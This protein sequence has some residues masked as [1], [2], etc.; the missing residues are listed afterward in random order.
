MQYTSAPSRTRF[1]STAAAVSVAIASKQS[2][3]P[4]RGGDSWKWSETEN[5]SKPCA[6]PNF[7]RRRISS[8]GPPMWP[9][10]IPNV[11]AI[12]DSP[13]RSAHQE[14]ARHLAAHGLDLLLRDALGDEAGDEHRVAVRLR[15]L[16]RLPEA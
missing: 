6:S 12:E 16:A 1:V 13:R 10:W 3:S 15:R 9:M 4:P 11:M 2:R 5:Q 7:Q 14:P 8:S